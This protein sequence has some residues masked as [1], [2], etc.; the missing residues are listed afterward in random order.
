VATGSPG[1]AIHISA[2]AALV[3]Y[4]RVHTGVHY[5][6]DVIAGTLTGASLAQIT[7]A[8]LGRVGMREKPS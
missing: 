4:A 6:A 7:A 3:A 8:A 5:P 1:A 2:A